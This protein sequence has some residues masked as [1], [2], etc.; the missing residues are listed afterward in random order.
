VKQLGS[1]VWKEWHETRGF[2]W[3]GLGV[4]LGLPVVAGLEAMAQYHHRFEISASPWVAIFG[5]VLAV[6]VAAGAT[7]RD[8]GDRLQDFW[9]SR[10]IGAVRWMLVKYFVGLAV[11]LAAC[12]LPLG[13]ELAFSR[14]EDTPAIF[15]VMWMPFFWTVLYSL[16]FLAGCLVRSTA[17]AAMLGLAAMLLVY[18]LPLVLPPLHWMSVTMLIEPKGEWVFAAEMLGLAVVPVAMALLA[19][20]RGWRIESGQRMMYGSISAAV[21]ILLASAAFQLGTNLPILQ[22]ADLPDGETVAFLRC[23]GQHGFVITN[24]TLHPPIG[25]YVVKSEYRTLELTPNGIK[26]GRPEEPGG[27]LEGVTWLPNHPE[28]G[29]S[30]EIRQE[31]AQQEQECRLNVYAM[32]NNF[33]VKS[34]HLWDQRP[35]EFWTFPS[36]MI[37]QNK[38]YVIGA[39]AV[40]LDISEPTA[41]RVISEQHLA[42]GFYGELEGSEKPVLWLPPVPGLPPRQW[43]EAAVQR[44]VWTYRLDGDI[45]CVGGTDGLRAFR[46]TKLTDVSATFKTIGE[47]K[48]TI[49]DQLFGTSFDFEMRMQNGMLYTSGW[50]QGRINPSVSV[51]DAAGPAPL[52]MVGHFAAPGSDFHVCPLPDGRALVGGTKIWLVGPPPRRDQ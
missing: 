12:L 45:L 48:Q 3:I 20:R 16:G 25:V 15:M 46:L 51:F 32:V 40:V 27:D 47:H 39:Y 22:Q 43:L 5:G 7:C 36:A 2:L 50:G 49:L 23:D 1:L 6:F 11:V 52:R 42:G 41:P 24:R 14:Q 8:L 44:Q 30:A 10:Q 34:L 28:I 21:L 38:L 9:R 31:N 4:F 19:V 17:H 35:Q 29:Y 26:L 13:L 18:F 33:A 37:W